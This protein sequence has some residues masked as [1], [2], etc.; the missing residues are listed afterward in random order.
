MR[1]RLNYLK[2]KSIPKPV[3]ELKSKKIRDINTK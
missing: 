1:I 3:F 2:Y